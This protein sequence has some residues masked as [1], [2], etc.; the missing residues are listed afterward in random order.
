M[1]LVDVLV[2]VLDGLDRSDTFHINVAAV[3][4]QKIGAVGNHSS[5][6]NL[7]L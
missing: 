2:N 4:P 3:F 6:V 5:I 7:M 1:A